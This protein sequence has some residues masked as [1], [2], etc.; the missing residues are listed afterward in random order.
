MPA[1]A[2]DRID[3][4]G[5]VVRVQA[6]SL[7]L[8]VLCPLLALASSEDGEGGEREG[9]DSPRPQMKCGRALRAC[10]LINRTA[11]GS[12]RGFIVD[13]GGIMVGVEAVWRCV[14]TLST[15]T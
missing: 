9:G 8:C 1:D 7:S 2:I 11:K 12:G 14:S 15:R 4:M 10:V 3:S 6:R 5:G 13:A